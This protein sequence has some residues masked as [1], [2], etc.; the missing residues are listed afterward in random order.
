M[1]T[2][3]PNTTPPASE[4]D[5]SVRVDPPTLPERMD[6][7][8]GYAQY[9][10]CVRELDKV[11]RWTFGFQPL[12][13]FFRQIARRTYPQRLRVLEVGFGSGTGLL[14]FGQ[15]ARRRELA[16]R[17]TGIELNP[18]A[19]RAARELTASRPPESWSGPANWL[20]GDLH[21]ERAAQGSDVIFSTLVTHHMRDAEIVA[22]L[23]WMEET[24]SVGWFINDLLRSARAYRVFSLLSRLLRWQ[25]LI[26]HDGHVS[27]RR[28]FREGD[29][30]RL[31]AEAGVPG[32]AVRLERT[33]PGRLCLTRLR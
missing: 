24:A 28:S 17:L 12:R 21:T 8:C 27:I 13:R 19:V 31:L 33:V 30:R 11:N 3:E 20:A 18:L 10:D 6:E 16:V 15:W 29:W 1:R 7:P 9:R 22:F 2:T 4:L 25:P 14:L 32:D 26:R 5:F 23:R